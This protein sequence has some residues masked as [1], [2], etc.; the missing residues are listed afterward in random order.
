MQNIVVIDY[1][2]KIPVYKQV[3]GAIRQAILNGDLAPGDRVAST[4]ELSDQL[5]LNRLTIVKAYNELIN[6]G[7]IETTVGSGTYVSLRLSARSLNFQPEPTEADMTQGSVKLSAFAD[8]LN[9]R[10]QD[11][12]SLELSAALNYGAPRQDELPIERWQQLLARA[13]RHMR[14]TGLT[15][16]SSPFGYRPLREAIAK[17]LHRARGANC[18]ANQVIIFPE[19]EAGTDLI[20]RLFLEAGDRVAVE[21]PGFPALRQTLAVQGL[22]PVGIPVDAHGL[23][24]QQLYSSSAPIKMAYVTPSHH[25]PTGVVLTL[26]RRFELLR[27]ANASG[28]IIIEDDYD[29][30]YRYGEEHVTQSLQGLDRHG[31]VI[32]RYNFWRALFPLVKLGFLV[33][34]QRFVPLFERARMLLGR[35]VSALEQQALAELI[36]GGHFE[37]HVRRMRPIYARRRAVLIQALTIHFGRDLAVSPV[38]AGMHLMVRFL[39][40]DNDATLLR[41]AE[42]AGFP[43]VS[44]R[45]HYLRNPVNGEFMIGFAHLTEE[46]LRAATSRFAAAI[47]KTREVETVAAP[48]GQWQSIITSLPFSQ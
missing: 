21:E 12:G 19:P 45:H 8:R 3:S 6:E 7:F 37:R 13:A 34:P 30:E 26:P 2:S 18:A 17:Y 41:A 35:D 27:W 11:P 48:A 44:T 25:D 42:E 40:R 16:A 23:N 29:S 31:T 24:V 28:S 10:V 33:V 32:Y 15:Y 38:S 39:T 14:D 43:M 47:Q 9:S 36:D 4:R 22:E 5:K 20:C 46:E 1:Q